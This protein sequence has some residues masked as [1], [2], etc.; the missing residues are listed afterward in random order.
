[1]IQKPSK[2][3]WTVL[4]NKRIIRLIQTNKMQYHHDLHGTVNLSVK[5]EFIHRSFH[6]NVIAL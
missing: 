6:S 4:K 3:L 1:M 2:Q 5:L